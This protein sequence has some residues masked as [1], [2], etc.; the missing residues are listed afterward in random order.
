MTAREGPSKHANNLTTRKPG[1]GNALYSSRLK[2]RQGRVGRKECSAVAAIIRVT[3]L[4]AAADRLSLSRRLGPK[5][6]P[7]IS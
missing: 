7:G 5:E 4:S 1:Q 3:G 6:D 2:S